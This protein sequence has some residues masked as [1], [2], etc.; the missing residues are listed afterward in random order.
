[1]WFELGFLMLHHTASPRVYR[2][3]VPGLQTRSR[4]NYKLTQREPNQQPQNPSPQRHPQNSQG[5]TMVPQARAQS[6]VHLTQGTY[7]QPTNRLNQ[8]YTNTSQPHSMKTA[9]G[10]GHG[11]CQTAQTAALSLQTGRMDC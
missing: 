5:N 11:A 3:C 8:R 6:I 4:V 9:H 2:R 7:Q 1:M 10:H